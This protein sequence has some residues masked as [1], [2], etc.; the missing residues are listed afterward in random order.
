MPTPSMN[1]R[2]PSSYFAS[3]YA[4]H[5]PTPGYVLMGGGYHGMERQDLDDYGMPHGNDQSDPHLAEMLDEHPG[6]M[7]GSP[8]NN[9]N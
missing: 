9:L 3:R 7:E 4:D 8:R 2:Y 5:G 1:H 6:Q